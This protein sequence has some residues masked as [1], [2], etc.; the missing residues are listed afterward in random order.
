MCLITNQTPLE[1]LKGKESAVLF[2]WVSAARARTAAAKPPGDGFMASHENNTADSWGHQLSF[3]GG[4]LNVCYFVLL[5][6]DAG[7]I[8]ESAV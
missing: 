4:Q 8:Q 1:A 2:S 7:F 6:N 3:V 5:E